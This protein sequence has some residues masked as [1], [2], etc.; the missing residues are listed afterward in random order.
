MNLD[1]LYP[2]G[3]GGRQKLRR[4]SW[5]SETYWVIPVQRSD[6]QWWFIDERAKYISFDT[7]IDDWEAC[8]PKETKKITLYRPIYKRGLFDE[9]YAGYTWDS[10]KDHFK[11]IDGR[12][13]V[14]WQEMHV[15]VPEEPHDAKS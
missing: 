6:D 4:K 3:V 2:R 1:D 8:E 10:N 7:S 11:A 13:P 14:A 12:K 5:K 15:D 9:Y